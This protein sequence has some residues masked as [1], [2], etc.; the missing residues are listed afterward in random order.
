[1]VYRK[2]KQLAAA[3]AAYIAGLVDGEGTITLSRKHRN[4]ARQL[5]LTIS[6]T[7]LP[8]LKHVLRSVGAGRITNKRAYKHSHSRSYT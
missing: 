3:E 1:M 6:S 2:V 4:E 8:L 5:S 7:E